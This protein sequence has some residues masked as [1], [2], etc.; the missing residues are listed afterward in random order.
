MHSGKKWWTPCEYVAARSPYSLRNNNG[1]TQIIILH[2]LYFPVSLLLHK[3]TRKSTHGKVLIRK[4]VRCA[5]FERSLAQGTADCFCFV[6][7]FQERDMLPMLPDVAFPNWET[8]YCKGPHTINASNKGSTRDLI[9]QKNAKTNWTNCK[10]DTTWRIS[11][12]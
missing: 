8:K 3:R 1:I 12:T 7:L 2:S 6:F 10:T 4:N 5:N 11:F 9:S